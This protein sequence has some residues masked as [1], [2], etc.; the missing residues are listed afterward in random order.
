[1]AYFTLL[2]FT[3]ALFRSQLTLHLDPISRNGWMQRLR[4]KGPP[5]GNSPLG[6]RMG[7]GLMM[8]RD[9]ERWRSCP[10]TPNISKTA[11]DAI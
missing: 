6:N 2:Y 5:I 3:V 7:T 9:P 10:N 8:S 1:M 11:E 4:S